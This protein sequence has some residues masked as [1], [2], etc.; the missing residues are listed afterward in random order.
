MHLKQCSL[1]I[2]FERQ[3]VLFITSKMLVL[4]YLLL[5]CYSLTAFLNDQNLSHFF[6]CCQVLVYIFAIYAFIFIFFLGG[7]GEKH[8][9]VYLA[10]IFYM[11]LAGEWSRDRLWLQFFHHQHHTT[12]IFFQCYQS[13]LLCKR[14]SLPVFKSVF[15]RQGLR[16]RTRWHKLGMSEEKLLYNS[17]K[18]LSK[19][20]LGEVK[21]S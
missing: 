18:L 10:F 15:P 3:L 13:K 5:I 20:K 16:H 7:G 2:S 8:C 4:P 9:Q 6:V 11:Q 1:S 12:L 17:E 14:L 21:I 19:P